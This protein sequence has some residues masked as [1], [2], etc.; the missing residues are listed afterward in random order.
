MADIASHS[1]LSPFFLWL[2]AY[3]GSMHLAA[4]FC[5]YA[6][7]PLGARWLGVKKLVYAAMTALAYLLSEKI[8]D[9]VDFGSSTEGFASSQFKSECIMVFAVH[10]WAEI[11]CGTNPKV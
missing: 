2:C 10:R 9:W 7:R 4:F 3:F 5:Y 8:R 11:L 1:V 6:V